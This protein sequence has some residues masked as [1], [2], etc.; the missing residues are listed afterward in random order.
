MRQKQSSNCLRILGGDVGGNRD[1]V[2]FSETSYDWFHKLHVVSAAHA[3]LNIV[4]L[5]HNVDRRAA[6]DARGDG[7]AGQRVTV[8][9]GAR[10]GV[11]GLPFP[12]ELLAFGDTTDRNVR[13]PR[14]PV[15]R[16]EKAGGDA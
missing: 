3:R 7:G 9:S 14:V 16:Q 6:G 11:A 4:E 15:Y 1:H 8:A 2:L 13:G 12:D 5:A 10:R